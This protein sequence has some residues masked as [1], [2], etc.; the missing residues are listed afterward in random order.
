MKSN[1]LETLKTNV[2]KFENPAL[3]NAAL[4]VI[5]NE[6]L[7]GSAYSKAV[8]WGKLVWSRGIIIVNE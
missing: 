4:G 3:K 1:D 2:S 6:D 5:S 7:G 8:E